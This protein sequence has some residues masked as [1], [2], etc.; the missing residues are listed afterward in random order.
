[1]TNG[2]RIRR[3]MPAA[4]SGTSGRSNFRRAVRRLLSNRYNIAGGLILLFFILLA[5]LPSKI[6]PYPPNEINLQ[7]SLQPPGASHWLGT[8]KLGRDLLSRIV[9]GSSASLLVGLGAVC[10]SFSCGTVLGLLAGYAGG[11]LGDAIMRVMDALW[12]LP[13]IILALGIATVLGPGIRNII[14]SV[15]ITFTP[16]FSRIVY[17]E[18]LVIKEQVYVRA[19]RSLGAS[20]L[21]IVFLEI[22]PNCSASLIVYAS[23]MA[24]QAIIAEAGLS[25]LGIGVVP[26]QAAWGSMLRAGYAYFRV[27]PWVSIFPG[28]AI[29]LIVLAFNFLGDGL[30]D[31]L[32]VKLVETKVG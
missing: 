15:G 12:S 30:R 19:A 27:A 20:D 25:F 29:F 18:V 13:A 22:L 21:R 1:M 10:F 24:G 16:A 8:D 26:P 28:L 3:T 17:A 11:R 6:A 5:L 9:H 7:Q 4:A 31:A 23:L 32:D 2:I 14:L